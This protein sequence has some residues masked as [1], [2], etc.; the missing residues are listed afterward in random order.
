MGLE[1]VI[2]QS[3][4]FVLFYL[5]NEFIHFIDR[6]KFHVWMCLQIMLVVSFIF[7]LYAIDINIV[8]LIC[9]G[10]HLMLSYV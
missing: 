4:S 2:E 7:I 10:F 8:D 3:S 9:C 5:F 1:T 6:L